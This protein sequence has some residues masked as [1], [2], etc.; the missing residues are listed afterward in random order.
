MFKRLIKVLEFLISSDQDVLS[1]SVVEVFHGKIPRGQEKLCNTLYDLRMGT[2][3]KGVKCET[4]SM[5]YT[6]C[7]DHFGHIVPAVSVVNHTCLKQLKWIVK[8]ICKKCKR[9]TKQYLSIK[10]YKQ[11]ASCFHSSVLQASDDMFDADN[12][13]FRRGFK[14]TRKHV[15]RRQWR[16]E[17]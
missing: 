7:N 13:R 3:E 2:I 15:L 6:K 16:L 1:Q 10:N 11:V 14:N 4:C 9:I 12:I 5:D 8:H 17:H